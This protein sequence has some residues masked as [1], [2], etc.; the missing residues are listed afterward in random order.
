MIKKFFGVFF[1]KSKKVSLVLGSGGFLGLSHIG[2][3]KSIENKG[4]KIDEIVGCSIGAIIGAIYALEPDSKKLEELAL[5]L[6]KKDLLSFLD[7][8][9]PKNSIL[10]GK[11]IRKFLE[12]V[13]KNKTFRETK[14][15]LKIIA[16]DIEKGKEV[17]LSKGRI[18]DAVMASIS[19][20][21][22][23]PPVRVG[24]RILVDGG[25]TNPTPIDK[26]SN[27]KVIAVDL[28]MRNEKKLESESIL[29]VLL[30][31]Y[32]IS[33]SELTKRKISKNNN[34]IL[35]KP[36]IY[37]LRSFKKYEISKFIE[38]GFESCN[39]YLNKKI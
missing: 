24:D 6:T 9:I 18:L 33:R 27:K 17:V 1:H 39:K 26:A 5:S 37:R 7:F 13:L 2:V 31:S 14:I 29:N 12:K 30:R 25:L 11:N 19:I 32:E 8:R 16:T 38:E 15:P 20:P 3:I 4:I 22:I 21:G 34:L 36:D 23:F 10:A 28:T 35:I